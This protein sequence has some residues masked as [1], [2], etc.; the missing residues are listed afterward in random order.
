MNRKDANMTGE[1]LLRKYEQFVIKCFARATISSDRLA[2]VA[3]LDD[4][5]PEIIVETLEPRGKMRIT[6]KAEWVQD[7]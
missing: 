2:Y 1:R 3:Y 7:E 5:R 6:V 4:D